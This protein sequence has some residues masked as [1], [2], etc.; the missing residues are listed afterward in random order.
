V[1]R[2]VRTEVGL[3]LTFVIGML[4]AYIGLGVSISGRD[5]FVGVVV[6]VVGLWLTAFAP[7]VHDRAHRDAGED[8]HAVWGN[9]D[10][11]KPSR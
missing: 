6:L 8:G 4:V 5:R 1:R 7:V 3:V 9:N 11:W 10:R 2:V